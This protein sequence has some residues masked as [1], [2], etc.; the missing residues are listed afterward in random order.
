MCIE[1]K[2]RDALRPPKLQRG[3]TRKDGTYYRNLEQDDL[4][5]R[6]DK[7]S[8]D[9]PPH[10]KQVKRKHWKGAFRYANKRQ[11]FGLS[12]NCAPCVGDPVCSIVLQPSSDKFVHVVQIDLALLSQLLVDTGQDGED[13]ENHE[14]VAQYS[15]LTESEN[16]FENPCHFDFL[17]ENT[18]GNEFI[19]AIADALENLF[20]DLVP[21]E[22]KETEFQQALDSYHRILH[23]HEDV[24]KSD[25]TEMDATA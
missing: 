8:D 19:M 10:G 9:D 5:K 22:R 21:S 24:R 20:G 7:D 17:P 3:D 14:L 13:E 15:P 2:C 25:S 1:K 18:S 12:V 23:I 16:G 11:S 4:K 6:Y